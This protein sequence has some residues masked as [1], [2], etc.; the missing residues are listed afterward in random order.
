[1]DRF[2]SAIEIWLRRSGVPL[3]AGAS[4]TAVERVGDHWEVRTRRETLETDAVVLALPPRSAGALVQESVPGLA[5]ILNAWPV[6]SVANLNLAFEASEVPQLPAGSGFVAPRAGGTP[7]SAATW[8]SRKWP[9]RAPEGKVLVRIYFGGARAPEAW[10][11]PETD[12]VAAG[13]DLLAGFHGGRRPRPLFHQVFR[14]KEAFAQPELGHAARHRAL[15]AQLVPG[16]V[17]AG[18]Y[19]AGVGIPDCLAR[20]GQASELVLKHL[21]ETSKENV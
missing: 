14:W 6:S 9:G 18:G 2:P 5:T 11:T 4:V 10:R 17:L 1:M 16:L 12:L 13:L 3:R 15:E 8:S 21:D 19:F 20:A 7:W